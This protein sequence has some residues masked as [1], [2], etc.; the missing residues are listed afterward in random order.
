[1]VNN[2]I[3]KIYRS[4]AL[5]LTIL[6]RLQKAAAEIDKCYYIQLWQIYYVQNP[7]SD[8]HMMPHFESDHKMAGGQVI[9][10]AGVDHNSNNVIVK[11]YLNIVAIV[12]CTR[13]SHYS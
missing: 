6:F 10:N 7:I 13:S 2:I 8:F 4:Q 1:M 12:V 5:I 9:K 11:Y 3:M